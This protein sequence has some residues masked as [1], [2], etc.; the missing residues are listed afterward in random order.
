MKILVPLLGSVSIK[1]LKVW[2]ILNQGAGATNLSGAANA[3]LEQINV[4]ILIHWTSIAMVD[5]VNEPNTHFVE[6]EEQS[7]VM[8]KH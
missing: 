4:T 7:V 6:G 3:F 5:S 1:V 8:C 2:S